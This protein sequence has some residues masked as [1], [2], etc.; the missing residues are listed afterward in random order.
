M[1]HFPIHGELRG[2]SDLVENQVSIM[3]AILIK[4][5]CEE[6]IFLRSEGAGNIALFIVYVD[7]F[8]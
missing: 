7:I 4:A 8:N 6:F 3:E 5:V 1:M 2:S